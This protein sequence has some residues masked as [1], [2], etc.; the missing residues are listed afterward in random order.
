MLIIN[1][2]INIFSISFNSITTNLNH[3]HW[4][5]AKKKEKNRKKKIISGKHI[6]I[7]ER[8]LFHERETEETQF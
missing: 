7:F 4:E 2:N 1:F 5:T 8:Q 6:Y 3:D